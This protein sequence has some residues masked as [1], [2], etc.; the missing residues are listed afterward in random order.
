MKDMAA[1][2]IISTF[3]VI[4]AMFMVMAIDESSRWT[5]QRSPDTG[6]CYEVMAEAFL[7]SISSA[8][9][10]IDDSFCENK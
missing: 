8:M 2:F 5:T 6:I 9:S 3:F 10:P 4:L 7:L 1:F